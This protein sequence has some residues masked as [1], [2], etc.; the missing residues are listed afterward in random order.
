[1]L[2]FQENMA[3]IFEAKT[4]YTITSFGLEAIGRREQLG[5]HS[6]TLSINACK[7]LTMATIF[8]LPK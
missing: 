8:G 6:H 7:K 3:Q 1:M 2:L 5:C 4:T